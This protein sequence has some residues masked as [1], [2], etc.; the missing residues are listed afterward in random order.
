MM[1]SMNQ[2]K[3]NLQKQH[4][5]ILSS[6]IITALKHLEY[7]YGTNENIWNDNYYETQIMEKGIKTGLNCLKMSTT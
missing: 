4:R 5:F 6:Q 1:Q 2:I 7:E 3:N